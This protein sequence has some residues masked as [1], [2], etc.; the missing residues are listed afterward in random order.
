M[1]KVKLALVASAFAFIALS[2]WAS[3][4]WKTLDY[5]KWSLKDVDKILNNSPWAKSITLPYY[6]YLNG[7]R[8]ETDQHIKIGSAPDP[9]GVADSRTYRPESIFT[10]RWNSALTVRRALYRDAVLRGLSADYAA[11][12]YLIDDE[13]EIEL[14]MI[15]IGQTLL[16]PAE[17][18][19]L[20]KETYL[21]L[22]P[23]GRKIQPSIAE[24]RPEVDSRGNDG[25]VFYFPKKMADGSPSIPKDATEINFFTQV[26]IRRFSI[27]FRPMEMIGTKGI[28]DY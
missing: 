21:Q 2:I 7:D 1:P 27:K 6:P 20:M 5:Q 16:P 14:T 3:E 9:S 4:P 24:Q 19:T 22:Q 8:P 15:P 26:G 10:L 28:E 18:V 11:H 17:P 13:E 12:R 23:S 25:Y